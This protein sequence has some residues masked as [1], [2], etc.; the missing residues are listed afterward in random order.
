MSASQFYATMDLCKFDLYE[1]ANPNWRFYCFLHQLQSEVWETEFTSIDR[2]R[3]LLLWI[4][5]N[6]VSTSTIL[7]VVALL[8]LLDT[9]YCTGVWTPNDNHCAGPTLEEIPHPFTEIDRTDLLEWNYHII[10]WFTMSLGDAS[11]RVYNW[12]NIAAGSLYRCLCNTRI[13]FEAVDT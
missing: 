12:Q 7:P 4:L 5:A 6:C 10:Y 1:E 8:R 11:S 9:C 2:L 3:S 13:E